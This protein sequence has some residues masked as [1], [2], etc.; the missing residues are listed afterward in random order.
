MTQNE[1]N[2]LIAQ[3]TG[4]SITTICQRGFVPLSS[5]PYEREPRTVDW[6]DADSQRGLLLQSRRKRA[7]RV[8]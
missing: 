8:V 1:L 2:Q 3:A 4:E 7:P 5:I 6:A